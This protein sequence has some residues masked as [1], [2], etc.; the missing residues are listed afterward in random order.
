M[1]RTAILVLA[2]LSLAASACKDEPE[3]ER[4]T[5][6]CLAP[7]GG[8]SPAY[9]G[10]AVL[11]MLGAERSRTMDFEQPHVNRLL[12]ISLRTGEVERERLLGARLVPERGQDLFLLNRAG[13]DVLAATPDRRTVLALVREAEQGGDSVAVLDPVTLEL[14]CTHALPNDV[15]Y[16]GLMLGRSG[17]FYA[18]GTRRA[19][20]PSRRDAVLTI[21]D[22]RTGR[23]A[24][25][26]TLR[27]AATGESRGGRDWF[28]YAAT[29]T[30][31]ERRLAV[32]FHGS[33]TTG[34]DLYRVSPESR[35]DHVGGRPQGGRTDIGTVHGEV[36]V[37]GGSFIGTN[38]EH[39]L[40]RLDRAGRVT[41][42]IP[43]TPP[44]HLMD[45][46]SEAGGSRIYTSLCRPRAVIQR[47]DL[48]R[49][50]AQGLP[51]GRSCGLPL[52]V[53]RHILVLSGP[54]ST[55]PGTRYEWPQR[56]LVVDLNHPTASFMIR[57]PGTPLDA[58]VLPGG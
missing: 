21:G 33:D 54:A 49:H 31:D 46:A 23:L 3:E 6:N 56:V 5:R 20:P 50:R 30:P 32:S 13:I 39:G 35:I 22:A 24:P 9:A 34:A 42:R 11:A 1:R 43:V 48:A 15:S 53:R 41:R 44:S 17:R 25:T 14:R 40:V 26:R 55:K 58:L 57:R 36:A 37:S 29:L 18:Y 10:P 4:S 45:F 19:E 7:S 12:R 27:H 16:L 2:I 8:P 51:T 47:L 28:A 52:T 38:A